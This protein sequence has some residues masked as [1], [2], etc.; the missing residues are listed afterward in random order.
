M[1]GC[2]G[3][4]TSLDERARAVTVTNPDAGW[5][6]LANGFTVN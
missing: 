2:L 1:K 4:L 3:L 6:T 5:Y